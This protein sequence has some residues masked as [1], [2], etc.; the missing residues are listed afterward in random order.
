MRRAVLTLAALVTIV[1]GAQ[2]QNY[3]TFTP[4]YG[5]GYYYH[6]NQGNYG[7]FTPNYGGGYYYHDNHGGY[8]NITPN[9]GGGYY[10]HYYNNN[11]YRGYSR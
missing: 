8:G 9:Y 11:P 10:Y 2:A 1:V 6:D 7:T 5:G 4:N 3:G